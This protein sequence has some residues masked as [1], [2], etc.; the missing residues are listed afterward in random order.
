[1]RKRLSF[2]L[3]FITL[4]YCA[5]AQTQTAQEATGS[6]SGHVFCS[7]TN[8]PA[9][10]AL[11]LLQPAPTRQE[12]PKHG[13]MQGSP[14]VRTGLD[15]SFHFPKVKPG[16][17]FLIADFAGY[18]S[19]LAKA[20]SQQINSSAQADVE[21]VEKLLVKVTVSANKDSSV[22][23]ELERGAALS[24]TVH[25]DDG[26]SASGLHIAL[27]HQQDDGKFQLLHAQ[28]G[29]LSFMGAEVRTD[30][31]GRFRIAGLPAGKYV[32]ETT[33]PSER[34]S[35][36]GLF[37]T[38]GMATVYSDESAALHVYSGN[39]FRLKEAKPIE[40]VAGDEH[41]GADIIVPLLGLHSVSGAVLA[42]RDDHA[43][44]AG[45][46]EL[47]YADDKTFMRKA[48]V[49]TDGRFN[50]LYVPA[51]DYILRVTNAADMVRQLV[52]NGTMSY[53]GNKLAHAYGS[54]QQAITVTDD[55]SNLIVRVP[56]KAPQKP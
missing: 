34:L 1:M 39:V 10:F 49:D 26:S 50:F 46:V 15:G 14:T 3:S 6:V 25:Y 27:Y 40:V 48:G 22:D 52:N 2:L 30:D 38:P 9:R 36:C 8:Q 51:G 47:D 33:F 31:N 16:T 18:I 42:V 28:I 19:P 45:E 43:L 17:Y 35:L 11:V 56:E 4:A 41:D 5:G 37:G 53:E 20:S 29:S 23:I 44:N 54:A 24:G 32:I 12:T 7:D 55:L 21:K 13:V